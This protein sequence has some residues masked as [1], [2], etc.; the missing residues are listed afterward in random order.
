[1]WSSK[2]D[3]GD[4]VV[5]AARNDDLRS[6]GSHPHPGRFDKL[7]RDREN[8]GTDA[9]QWFIA[10]RVMS[11]FE[12]STAGYRVGSWIDYDHICC[13][14]PRLRMKNGYRPV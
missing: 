7:M 13:R 6:F 14:I 11:V 12:G 4:D 9:S 2:H 10:C 5:L 3:F 8:M 1:M